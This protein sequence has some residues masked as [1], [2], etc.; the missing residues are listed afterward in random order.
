MNK[1][2]LSLTIDEMTLAFIAQKDGQTYA[3]LAKNTKGRDIKGL[4]IDIW[5]KAPRLLWR[6][7]SLYNA[8]SRKILG[9]QD[10]GLPDKECS[11]TW[12]FSWTQGTG[13]RRGSTLFVWRNE[14]SDSIIYQMINVWSSAQHEIKSLYISFQLSG[15]FVSFAE[16]NMLGRP[17]HDYLRHVWVIDASLVSYGSV[18]E[19]SSTRSLKCWKWCL[20]IYLLRVKWR[21]TTLNDKSFPDD[22][23]PLHFQSVK[24][25]RIWWRLVKSSTS[26]W[27]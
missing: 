14:R 27:E 20:M 15:T 10:T 8:R 19:S 16:N 5:S 3:L 2:C 21:F 1:S 12:I 17:S 26:V 22:I 25:T 13:L 23:Y 4:P 11:I 7:W 18:L 6:S 24:S 9:V